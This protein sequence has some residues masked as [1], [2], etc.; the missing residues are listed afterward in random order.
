MDTPAIGSRWT[1]L[2]YDP[3]KGLYNAY[4]ILFITNTTNVNPN[5][6]PQ[7]VYKGD[8]GYYW[9]RPFDKWPGSLIPEKEVNVE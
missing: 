6:P 4:T 7:I 1:R 8:N 2:N 5:H 3:G 9:S